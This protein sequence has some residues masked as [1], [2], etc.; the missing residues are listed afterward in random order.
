M[1]KI[2]K[3][4]NM[5]KTNIKQAIETSLIADSYLLGSH[6]I[7]DEAQL[8]KLDIDWDTLNAPCV[9]W[10][11]GKEK[12]DFTHYGDQTKWLLD[13]V[14]ESGVF[15]IEGYRDVWLE[16][17][18]NYKGYI[19]GSSRES[20]ETFEKDKSVITGACCDDLSIV[21]RI[22]PLLL[23]SSSKE[24]FLKN[25]ASFVSLTHNNS[26]VLTVANFF[27]SVLYSVVEGDEIVR[28]ID[29]ASIDSNLK[30][31]LDEAVDSMGKDTFETIRN[32]GPACGV[33]G[34]FEG[35]IHLLVTY[36]NNF[37]EA[38]IA[39]AKAGGDSSA[40]G[41]IVG[42]IMGASGCKIPQNWKDDTKG[43]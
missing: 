3:R 11:K 2:K 28:A 29:D 32:F 35:A 12:G 17:M 39:N 26:M 4:D 36:N 7:Y 1:I 14:E 34:G 42:M 37:K 33:E 40:R 41:M 27:A 18:K 6:W 20:I 21:G 5:N 25:V 16:K 13:Y 9:M 30:E 19:D 38:M 10:H 23:V 31:K 43:V 24:E 22:A 8:E 15:E